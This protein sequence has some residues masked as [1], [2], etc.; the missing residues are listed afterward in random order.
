MICGPMVGISMLVGGIISWGYLWPL[1]ESKEGEWYKPQPFISMTGMSGY[2]ISVTIA[3][4]FGDG[5]YHMGVV[6]LQVCYEFYTR[7]KQK[8][9]ILPFK[10]WTGP[11]IPNMS[12]DDRRR[13]NLFVQDRIPIQV[14]LG[15]Y[16]LFA[17]IS[18]IV[19]PVFYP[20]LHSFQIGAAYI[21]APLLS[22]SNAYCTGL[23][24]WNLASAFTKFTIFIFGA[25]TTGDKPGSVIAALGASGVVTA[26]VN[27]ASDLMADF[28][29]GY[30]TM[31]SPRSTFVAQIVGTAMGCIMAPI[32]YMLYAP[33]SPGLLSKP[34][35]QYPAE[36]GS[37]YRI[38]AEFS[39]KGFTMLP[40]Y[41][42]TMFVCF[43]VGTILVNV[44]R[45]VARGRKWRIYPFIPS[46][47][48]MAITCFSGTS[49][50][51]DMLLGSLIAYL[52][53]KKNKRHADM[54]L[55]L[56]A[57]GMIVGDTFSEVTSNILNRL[58]MVPPF[59]MRF[60]SRGQVAKLAGFLARTP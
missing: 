24:D 10:L 32:C 26:V 41:S 37:T 53:K 1:V 55:S 17:T 47:L 16:I 6:I 49:N 8:H 21:L 57:S 28:R 14:A 56:V 18:A 38:M 4:A 35:Q 20:S 22:F 15:G 39:I 60:L 36:Y 45:E 23:T 2:V 33:E 31:T 29:T 42:V 13:T 34:G 7:R 52:W 30:M 3:I 46:L 51:F 54:F 59:C 44:F 25:W 5:I 48:P 9:I 19:I 50:A 40:K 11:E 27:T 58:E 43:F 12:Y